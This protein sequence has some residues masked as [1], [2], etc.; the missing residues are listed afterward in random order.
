M[1]YRLPLA[2]IL[3]L[4]GG[5]AAQEQLPI[6]SGKRRPARIVAPGAP[7]ANSAASQVN[8]A[9]RAASTVGFL[10]GANGV[11]NIVALSL[12]HVGA[13]PQGVGVSPRMARLGQLQFDRR[14]ST[15]LK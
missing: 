9:A 6:N 10:S 2:T 11:G 3:L 5:L 7:V 1:K 13:N 14:P 4:A 12:V 8:T 15:I